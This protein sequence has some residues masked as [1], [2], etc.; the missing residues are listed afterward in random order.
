MDCIDETQW[1]TLFYT[2]T[3]ANP[4]TTTVTVRPNG[5]SGNCKGAAGGKI[6]A[7]G[8]TV[9]I[10]STAVPAASLMSQIVSSVGSPA[11]AALGLSSAGVVPGAAGA[12]A[13]GFATTIAALEGTTIVAPAVGGG[14]G[15]GGAAGLSGGAIAGIVIG[16]VAGAVLIVGVTT[17]V[18]AALIVAAVVVV[19]KSGSD[20]DSVDSGSFRSEPTTR[21]RVR[22]TINNFFRGPKGG[23]D[24]MNNPSGH[25]SITARSPEA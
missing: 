8:F 7:S 17:V 23:V 1:A 21:G 24:V 4:A 15:G 2:L 3:G 12:N 11:G 5:E 6:I 10:T 18:V 25:Q 9:V 20:S 13:A 14:G 16:S 22:D 19:K